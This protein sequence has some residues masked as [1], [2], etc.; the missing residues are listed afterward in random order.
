MFK[1][2]A[3]T[4]LLRFYFKEVSISKLGRVSYY[5]NVLQL[6]I[7]NILTLPHVYTLGLE[8]LQSETISLFW[9]FMCF[10]VVDLSCSTPAFRSRIWSDATVGSSPG[11]EPLVWTWE[12]QSPDYVTG[13]NG[14]YNETM[15]PCG[16]GQK[17]RPRWNGVPASLA[18]GCG[19]KNGPGQSML[20]WA[21][22]ALSC[23]L[24]RR[25][26]LE[27]KRTNLARIGM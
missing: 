2:H 9:L 20:C 3:F 17:P 13:P 4:C 8:E 26:K 19:S 25:V 21:F 16:F 18:C 22:S 23:H 7:V 15:Q 11:L 10:E 14:G 12:W 1:C 5:S 24:G 6:W 27:H